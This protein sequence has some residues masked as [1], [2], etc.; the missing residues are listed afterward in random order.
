MY[1]IYAYI[2]VRALCIYK[3]SKK[4]VTMKPPPKLKCE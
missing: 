1:I 3:K 4:E 2:H